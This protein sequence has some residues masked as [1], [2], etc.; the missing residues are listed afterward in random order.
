MTPNPEPARESPLAYPRRVCRQAWRD[1]LSVYYANTP[2]WRFLKSSGLLVL[3]LFCWSASSLL[4]SYRPDWTILWYV[5]AYGFA[6]ILWGPLTHFVIVPLVIRL[7]RTAEH[8]VTRGLSR[9]ASKLNLTVFFTIVILLGTFPIAPMTLEFQPDFGSDSG[10]DV[11]ATLECTKSTADDLVRCQISS[12]DGV[13]HVVVSSAGTELQTVD[14]PPFEFE[15]HTEDL[16]EVVG[17]KQ[18]TVEVRDAEGDKL[19]QF[20]RNLDAIR[21][22]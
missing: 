21:E 17:Q 5:A 3:G 14:E 16:E 9:H 12:A 22:G 11:D 20:T 18:F 4:L 1:T 13:D 8:P 10:P 15:L 6:L 2:I 19:R 7:R